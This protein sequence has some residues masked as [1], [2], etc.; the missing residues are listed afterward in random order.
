MEIS[1]E[2]VTGDNYCE[3]ALRSCSGNE[4]ARE[5]F[6]QDTNLDLLH[7]LLGMAGEVGEMI[8][9]VKKAAYYGKPLDMKKLEEEFGDS[10]WYRPL[11]CKV[12]GKKPSDIE[13]SNITKLAIRYPDKFSAEKAFNRD[14]EAEQKVFDK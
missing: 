13:L 1:K 9:L 5:F 12:L 11:I 2:L 10:G 14:L 6:S 7:G 4:K 8:D 3:A